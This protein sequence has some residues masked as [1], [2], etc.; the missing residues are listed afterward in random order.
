MNIKLRYRQWQRPDHVPPGLSRSSD[1]EQVLPGYALPWDGLEPYDCGESN[2]IHIDATWPRRY[3]LEHPPRGVHHPHEWLYIGWSCSDPLI[4]VSTNRGHLLHSLG[5]HPMYE[6]AQL[7][8]S[9]PLDM[10]APPTPVASLS[11]EST[12]T[13][14]YMESDGEGL[15]VVLVAACKGF[16]ITAHLDVDPI[17]ACDPPSAWN[18]TEPYYA[19]DTPFYAV[20]NINLSPTITAHEFVTIDGRQWRFTGWIPL[21]ITE[22]SAIA[23]AALDD[24]PLDLSQFTDFVVADNVITV[25]RDIFATVFAMYEPVKLDLS[26]G[27]VA[28]DPSVVVLFGGGD[29]GGLLWRFSDLLRGNFQPHPIPP[30]PGFDPQRFEQIAMEH[31]DELSRLAGSDTPKNRDQLRAIF[32]RIVRQSAK[33]TIE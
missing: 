32:E 25:P 6:L 22:Q 28:I 7:Q 33:Q 19:P 26:T 24:S 12:V 31:A 23:E 3:D 16:D 8:P 21:N 1:T 14:W 11:P 17:A 2:A 9:F 10:P 27:T 5:G 18:A 4:S 30:Y 15:G 13:A 29:A 20:S